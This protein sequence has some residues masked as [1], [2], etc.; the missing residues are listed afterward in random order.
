M[1][2]FVNMLFIDFND[3][4]KC[5]LVYISTYIIVSVWYMYL[6]MLVFLD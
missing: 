6:K 5:V 2:D 1:G 3:N 4:V